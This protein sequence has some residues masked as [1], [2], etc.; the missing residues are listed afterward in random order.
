MPAG[1]AA[2]SARAFE[3][4]LGGFGSPAQPAAYRCGVMGSGEA[5]VGEA[6][7]CTGGFALGVRS[8]PLCDGCSLHMA[9]VF[10]L[11]GFVW[12]CFRCPS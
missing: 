11:K 2:V 12:I 10:A 3:G 8:H 7:S 1:T 6:R 9:S 5:D 4:T